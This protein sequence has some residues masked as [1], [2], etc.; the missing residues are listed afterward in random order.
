MS[1]ASYRFR[2][3]GTDVTVLL[4]SSHRREALRV[5]R[6]FVDWN[7]RM[8]RFRRDSELSRANAAAG[9]GVEVSLITLQVIA[10]ALRAAEASDGRFDPLLGARMRELGYDRT[11]A[12]LP[13]D[14]GWT[15]PAAWRP[16][17]WREIQ[18]DAAASRV[19]VPPGGE[20]DLGG[21]AKGMAVD[22]AIDVLHAAG[23][24]YALVNAGGDLA[25]H[26][27]PPESTAGWPV[28]I[29]NVNLAAGAALLAHGALATSSTL[30]RRWR[31]GG[32]TRHHLLDPLSGL[33]MDGELAQVTVTA[34]SCRQAEVA[35]KVAIGDTLTGASAFILRHGLTAAIV[36]R[37]GEQVRIGRWD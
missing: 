25:V 21:I 12:A 3:M 14:R 9:T 11:F 31:A 10:A 29:D 5:Q 30:A 4:P 32:V 15:I 24:P 1:T 19:R 26:G 6:L 16:S 18:I 22:A 23:V 7:Q 17:L 37:A 20:L 2:S 34:P 33:P 28:S 8:S 36:T 13:A 35:A 27:S